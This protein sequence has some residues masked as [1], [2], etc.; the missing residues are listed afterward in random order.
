M[1]H[2]LHTTVLTGIEPNQSVVSP[3]SIQYISIENKQTSSHVNKISITIDNAYVIKLL[4]LTTKLFSIKPVDGFQRKN[5]PLDYLRLSLNEEITRKLRDLLVKHVVI[6]KL[7][8]YLQANK[9]VGCN[10]PRL[11]AMN[12]PEGAHWSFDFDLSLAHE[13]ELKE[14]RNF[15]FK[16][17]KRKK[18]KDLDKQV[19]NFLE[20]EVAVVK[21]LD[22]DKVEEQ[23]WVYSEST[24]CDATGEILEPRITSNFWINVKQ[25]AGID[26]LRDLF[27]GRQVGEKF[28]TNLLDMD[29]TMNEYE[30]YRYYFQVIIK[31]IVKGG[32]LSLELFK[33]NFKLK[34]KSDVHNKLMEVFSFRNDESQRRSTIEEVFH[35]LLSK[36]RFEV[37]KHLVLRRQEDLLFSIMKKP[38]YQVYKAQGDFEYHLELLAEK[39]LKEE[40]LVDQISYQ[41]GIHDEIVD[42]QHYFHLFGNK[43]LYEFLYFKPVVAHL[44]Q[45][46]VPFNVALLQQTFTREK[47]LNY[48][49]HA[50]TN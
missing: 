28:V 34:N 8:T 31:N 25:H 50:M 33:S 44:D 47:T 32:H 16:Q 1:D 2:H 40:I 18:Y 35:L 26:V 11:I 49:I 6:N 46:N 7:S 29:H 20:H 12:T 10:Y 3:E 42:A 30:N 21:K 37:P 19:A 27:I 4:D 36:H 22:S 5:V 48:I 13:I 38:D 43:K 14:W 15:S 39:Q 41:E 17:P 24:L 45:F 9:I 23:D